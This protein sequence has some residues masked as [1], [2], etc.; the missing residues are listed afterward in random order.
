MNEQGPCDEFIGC[1][2]CLCVCEREREREWVGV[3]VG[4]IVYVCVCLCVCVCGGIDKK[5][6]VDILRK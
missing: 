5:L 2:N 6:L 3:V 1:E 4:V